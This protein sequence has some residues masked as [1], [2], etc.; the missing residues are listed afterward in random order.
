MKELTE[1]VA[2]RTVDRPNGVAAVSADV[3]LGVVSKTS[4]VLVVVSGPVRSFGRPLVHVVLRPPLLP[5]QL[6][7][8]TWLGRAARRGTATR[9]EVLV[10]V[11]GLLD[12]LIPALVTELLHHVDLTQ[13]VQQNVDVVTL[14]EEVIAEI[15]LPEI[16]RDSTSAVASDTLL[17]VRMQSISGDEAI[18]RAMDR[19]KVRLARRTGTTRPAGAT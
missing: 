10:E 3:V 19:L 7:P 13:L 17:G 1:S 18:G 8:A 11:E 16:I 12:R 9:S 6:Q 2:P 14:A 15:D 4:S 5:S